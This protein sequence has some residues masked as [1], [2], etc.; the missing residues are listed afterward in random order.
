MVDAQEAADRIWLVLESLS[1]AHPEMPFKDGVLLAQKVYSEVE[2]MA[3]QGISSK[4]PVGGSAMPRSHSPAD[5]GSWAGKQK[6]IVAE[7]DAN[8]KIVAIKELRRLTSSDLKS[9]KE[10]IEWLDSNPEARWDWAS[11]SL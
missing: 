4:P 5:L 10:A 1:V 8:R 3:E 2:W 7:I 11:R 6:D 9:A